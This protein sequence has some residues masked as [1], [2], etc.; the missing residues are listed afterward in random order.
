MVQIKK[1]INNFN[2]NCTFTLL[3]DHYFQ[4]KLEQFQKLFTVDN[5]RTMHTG[6]FTYMP[7]DKN[8][9]YDPLKKNFTQLSSTSSICSEI[10]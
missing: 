2:Y 7:A 1:T 6:S 3:E 9:S 4:E 10:A 5:F 8:W